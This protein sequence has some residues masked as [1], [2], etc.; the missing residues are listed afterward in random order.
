MP[1]AFFFCNNFTD[2]NYLAPLVLDAGGRGEQ[3]RLV[4]YGPDLK[5]ATKIFF[6]QRL[7][8]MLQWD[9][10]QAHQVVTLRNERALR[11]FWQE[12]PGT[13]V[14]STPTL[15]QLIEQTIV[16]SEHQLI[17][18]GYFGESLEETIEHLSLL[19]LS[20]PIWGKELPQENVRYGMPYWDLFATSDWLSRAPID[21]FEL[22]PS[23]KKIVLPEIMQ[24]GDSWFEE[25]EAYIHDYYDQDAQYYLKYRLKTKKEL[26]R[27]QKLEKSLKQ[28]P[29]ITPVY[30][31]Y[32]FTTVRL[33]QNADVVFT[34]NASLFV[35]DCM[36]AGATVVKAFDQSRTVWPEPES[37][38]AVENYLTNPAETTERFFSNGGRST[39]LF[40]QEFLTL[41]AEASVTV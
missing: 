4:F 1:D 37:N 34:S 3:L 36:A 17:G 19:F 10:I 40:W 9:C 30:S 31:P 6:K 29:N 22:A 15:Q 25:A 8:E 32:F 21:D 7:P 16:S 27:N 20:S 24:D 35:V 2:L 13:V 14:A 5:R 39:A 41:S 18:L 33:L 23:R 26:R 12:H 28:Y 38:Q 11:T